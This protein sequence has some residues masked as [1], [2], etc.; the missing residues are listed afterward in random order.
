MKGLLR[1]R[2]HKKINLR[3]VLAAAMAIAMAAPAVPVYGAE[4]GDPVN[5]CFD[6]DIGP[7]LEY[8]SYGTDVIYSRGADGGYVI[9]GLAGTPLKDSSAFDNFADMEDLGS[10]VRPK[11]P[12]FD[13]VD[14]PGYEFKG[15]KNED[16]NDVTYL[17]YAFPY[18][19]VTYTADWAGDSTE[20]FTFTVMH[21]RDLDLE[22]SERDDSEAWP[23]TGDD[24]IIEFFK[25]DSSVRE[26]TADTPVS[27][28]YR[29][30]IPGYK[31]HS[32][33]IK[34]NKLRRYG[35]DEGAGTL[36]EAASIN[37]TTNA[38]SGYMPND[39]LTVAYR[40]EPDQ[41]KTFPL[42]IECVEVN[43]GSETQIR[44]PTSESHS[45]E[46]Q[47]TV[48]VPTIGGYEL[49]G[50]EYI[51]NVQDSD[52][53]ASQGVYSTIDDWSASPTS[54]T[55]SGPMPNQ[56]MTVK[57][58][59]QVDPD[60][61][62]SVR[63]QYLDEEGNALKD[64]SY[65]NNVSLGNFEVNIESIDGY[66]FS[67]ATVTGDLSGLT[68][69]SE[70][71]NKVTVTVGA[72]GG[73]ITLQ[74]AKNENDSSYWAKVSYAHSQNGTLTGDTSPRTMK[75]GTYHIDELTESRVPE[76]DNYYMFDGWYKGTGAGY[77]GEK[78]EGDVELTGDM[79]LYA[80]FVKD[81]GQWHT[82]R[83]EA[84]DNGTISNVGE[85]EYHTGTLWSAVEKPATITP[86]DGYRFDGWYD[87]AGHKVD[88]SD[89]SL[90]ILADQTY[91][92]VF[93][94]I[95]SG[96]RFS[97]PDASGSVGD[98]GRG[99]IQVDGTNPV[100][101]YVLT[102][103]EGIILQVKTGTELRSAPFEG[104]DPCEGYHV[105]EIAQS[106]I[107]T[108][109]DK[110][111]ENI[112][113]SIDSNSCSLPATVA[114][115]ALGDNYQLT[116]NG[117]GK[118]IVIRPAASD[119]SYAILNADGEALDQTGSTDGWVA[120]SG[121]PLSVELTGLEANTP[122]IVVAKPDS[123]D[124]TPTDRLANGSHVIAMEAE[125]ER[126]YT[127]RILDGT[128]E[129]VTRDGEEVEF[130]DPAS[131]RVKEGD[132]INITAEAQDTNGQAFETWE[133]L[134]GDLSLQ[135]P[136]R[137]SQTVTMPAGDV[138]L[139]AMY[140][141][142]PTATPSNATLDYSPKDGDFALDLSGDRREE[143]LGE[144]TDNAADNGLGS[145]REIEYIVKFQ[146][147]RLPVAS[148]SD[149]VMEEYDNPDNTK[150]LWSLDIGLER[151]VDGITTERDGMEDE[152]EEIRVFAKLRDGYLDHL[153]YRL[154]KVET[155]DEVTLTSVDM[156]PNPNDLEEFTGSFA[157]VANIGD[158]LLLSYTKANTVTILDLER[159]EI[160]LCRVADDEA[161]EDSE[162]YNELEIAR[163]YEGFE[164]ENGAWRS[165]A[166]LSRNEDG[167]T[168]YDPSRAVTRDITL[169][170]IY[171]E[172]EDDE[173][174]QEAHDRLRE[175]LDEAN[176]IKNNGSI[177][178]EDRQALE[179]AIEEAYGVYVKTD[180]RPTVE[181]LEAA[182][183]TLKE[184]VDRVR[185]GESGSDGE[186]GDSGS[187]DDTG[188]QSGG[189]GSGSGGG[190]HGGGSSGGGG[191]SSSG[192]GATGNSWGNG[193]RTYLEGTDGSWVSSAS[194]QWSFVLVSGNPIRD[195]WANIRSSYETGSRTATYHFNADGMLDSG[196]F[197][198][199][200]TGKWYYL[201]QLHD[202]T[203]GELVMGW[204]Y[205]T[206]DGRWYYLSHLTGEMML[207][208]QKVSGRWYYLNPSSQVQ[209]WTY[210]G[211]FGRWEYTNPLGRPFGSLYVGEMTPDGYPVDENGIW[212]QETP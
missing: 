108:I 206:S 75:K 87:E 185:N 113:G 98:D 200:S 141:A 49:L 76:A 177:S 1:M 127:F 45:A 149:A 203:F 2:K 179:D 192:S 155:E 132:Q 65:N 180:P 6:P 130:D 158:T 184:V 96:D 191:S 60:Y 160:Y 37:Q 34:N 119:T 101:G 17:S 210:N 57:F 68:V 83:F 118:K 25:D 136:T 164:D 95:S 77:T 181:E 159:G 10:G 103:S 15:W 138:V 178:Q 207:G 100:L 46:E 102:D 79:T 142:D 62:T 30:D 51:D 71:N 190:S 199:V 182:Y 201:S 153:D 126:T 74:Y 52:S 21:Y 88:T 7:G 54:G 131:V 154:Y 146:E 35:E 156:E 16:G 169:Y 19:D 38:L 174:W 63:I 125:R 22:R 176:A 186:P 59:Y 145:S 4:Y 140:Q 195:S 26:V 12:S 84:G 205:D 121:S 90:A 66:L 105:Y 85:N 163:D 3:R 193:Y 197:L 8:S 161:L 183:E 33:L 81:P 80:N 134:I 114:V 143:L 28:T 56:M 112:D 188:G 152:T 151:K 187:S 93:V 64:P 157:F 208:W 14:W 13:D 139:A 168:L 167:T 92:A 116:D 106:E 194:D 42:R 20:Q 144:L 72:G 89:S 150:I 162:A 107:E 173:A 129:S 124:D 212:Q 48:E 111:G 202:G 58:Q 67:N 137:R 128:V 41:N 133:V 39:N 55:V 50:V 120:A 27:A 166:G 104:L 18:A 99:E 115:P 172:P 198:D 78:L 189:N 40:Y 32:V 44:V 91:T 209:T 61:E 70:N 135:Y 53:L 122:Y 36:G 109:R 175:E 43:G 123:S 31:L 69:D 171:R 196:W 47:V 117:T 97:I 170:V 9:T 94:P 165:F 73:V 5:L 147:K 23:A 11:L 148:A 211:A 110:I 86:N 29:R 24:S 204:H 82:I